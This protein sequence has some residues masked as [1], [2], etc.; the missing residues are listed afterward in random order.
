[1]AEGTRAENRADPSEKII[2][3]T[4]TNILAYTQSVLHP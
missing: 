4:A 1:M 2:I 3:L